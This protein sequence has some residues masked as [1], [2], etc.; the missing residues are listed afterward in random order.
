M[1][2]KLVLLPKCKCRKEGHSMCCS[3][4]VVAVTHRNVAFLPD[5]NSFVRLC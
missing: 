1:I 4:P 5:L 2:V 3:A